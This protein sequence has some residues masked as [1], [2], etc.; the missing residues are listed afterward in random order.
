M[1]RIPGMP[2]TED[3][4]LLSGS[5][6]LIP[7]SKVKKNILHVCLSPS[8]GGLELNCLRV[9]QSFKNDGYKTFLAVQENSFLE[10]KCKEEKLDFISLNPGK[11]YFSLMTQLK[12]KKFV[13][14]NE[15]EVIFSHYLRDLW[16]LYWVKS[17]F[18]KTN[19]IGLTQMYVDLPKKDFLHKL[20][21]SKLDHLITLTNVQKEA[22]LQ[23]LPVPAEKYVVI[24]NGV[25]T[26]KFE[27]QKKDD[28]DRVKLRKSL[29]IEKPHEVLV[30]VIGRFD[31]QKGQIELMDAIPTL[32]ERHPHVKYLFLGADTAG[33]E[34]IQKIIL[35]KILTNKLETH[36]QV[37]GFTNKIPQIMNALDI[38]I[39]PSYKEA[40]GIVLIEAMALEKICI[41]TNAGGPIE[42]LE[43]GEYGI[44]IEPKSS[45]HIEAAISE[46]V[47]SIRKYEEKAKKARQR[48][49]QKYRLKDVFTKIK[50]L[51]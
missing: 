29:G 12:L 26:D 38:F 34:S 50:E 9:A 30:G 41:A 32:K 25:D 18:P 42:I 7:M 51:T 4:T 1:G 31:R 33:E 23:T 6:I 24:P 3:L 17:K 35:D 45:K 20:I 11:K 37:R 2:A 48:V 16:H 10:K 44:L 28:P 8:E 21:Y 13:Q 36:V 47:S 19:L 22:L 5:F 43:K 49:L 27:P 46:V 14:V 39:L 40:F 15:I